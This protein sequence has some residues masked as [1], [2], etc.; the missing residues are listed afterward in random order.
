MSFKVG[1]PV[2]VNLT[3]GRFLNM[4]LPYNRKCI[5]LGGASPYS[6]FPNIIPNKAV[7]YSGCVGMIYL[8]N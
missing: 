4:L 5:K 7:V 3:V 2:V 8:L 6:V 1:I